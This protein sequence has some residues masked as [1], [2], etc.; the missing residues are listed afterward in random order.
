MTPKQVTQLTDRIN[1]WWPQ[2][3]I[4]P[5]LTTHIWTPRFAYLAA[6]IVVDALKRYASAKQVQYPPSTDELFAICEEIED[7]RNRAA[8]QAKR[9]AEAK[10]ALE[11]WQR[12]NRHGTAAYEERTTEEAISAVLVDAAVDT[13]AQ[14]HLALHEQGFNRPGREQEAAEF[15]RKMAHEQPEDADDWFAEAFWWAHGAKGQLPWSTP[16]SRGQR[17]YPETGE[18]R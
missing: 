18:V 8:I 10:I 4:S 2:A 5:D 7:E 1:T 13:W 9:D 3:K 11:T 12:S 17:S 6:E 15:C 14:G 16:M